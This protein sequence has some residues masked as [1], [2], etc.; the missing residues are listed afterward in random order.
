[1]EYYAHMD[2]GMNITL[3]SKCG[4]SI[5]VPSSHLGYA[6]VKEAI[7]NQDFKAAM[8]LA[9]AATA[10]KKYGGGRVSI[11]DGVLFFDGE[12][13][14]NALTSRIIRMIRNNDP[15]DAM[16]NFL[17]NL[18][19]NPSQRAVQELYRFL[20]HNSLPLTPD[21]IRIVPANAAAAS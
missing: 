14:H 5:T 9:D 6:Q 19:L 11:K 8:E 2:N 3:L 18:Q 17:V 16:V 1:M 10:I 7:R 15:V 21:A 20:E 13:M 4:R 12:E